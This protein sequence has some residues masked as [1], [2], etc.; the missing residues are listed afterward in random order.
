MFLY[1]IL[2]SFVSNIFNGLTVKQLHA[3]WNC[4]SWFS[5]KYFT[6]TTSNCKI[7]RISM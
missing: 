6:K 7:Q 2:P 3:L 4:F 5:T 1:K